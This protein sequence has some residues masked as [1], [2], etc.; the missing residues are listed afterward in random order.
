MGFFG[1]S[2]KY[3]KEDLHREISTLET[4]YRQAIGVN[5]T[6]KSRIQLKQ[7]LATQLYKILDICKKGNFNG[8]ESVLWCG[9]YTSLRNVTPMVQVFIE[10]M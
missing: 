1:F 10:M 9:S 4:L 6:T 3:T 5:T 7:E 8:M 2:K